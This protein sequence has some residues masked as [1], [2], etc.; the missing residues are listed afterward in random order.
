MMKIETKTVLFDTE[1]VLFESEIDEVI[2][3]YSDGLYMWAIITYKDTPN[4]YDIPLLAL[5]IKHKPVFN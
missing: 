4:K 3:Y 2:E 1:T 5:A